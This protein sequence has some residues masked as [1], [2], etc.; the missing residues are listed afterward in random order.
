M[1]YDSKPLPDDELLT[2][3]SDE[4][5]ARTLFSIL[6]AAPPLGRVEPMDI[7][8]P[9]TASCVEYSNEDTAI[10]D[11]GD[12][13]ALSRDTEFDLISD[14][15]LAPGMDG[16]RSVAESNAKAIVFI[17]SGVTDIN[18]I[19]RAAS[20]DAEIVLLDAKSDG[21]EQIA[22]H[23][24][25]RTGV[26]KMH[27]VSY[28]APGELQLGNAT[29]SLSSITGAHR[30]GLAIVGTALAHDACILVCGSE[31]L[32]STKGEAFIQ[33]LAN[34]TGANVYG[35]DDPAWASVPGGDRDLAISQRAIGTFINVVP[36][37]R[38]GPVF[39]H[40]RSL[41]TTVC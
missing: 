31:D 10:S 8:I 24:Q 19:V 29:L 20:M 21:I 9:L 13:R 16:A 26:E 7:C 3:P 15:E 18:T 38:T 2:Q 40:R 12:A 34:V 25:G 1:T 33:A 22:S 37:Y 35:S 5:I 14:V 11:T 17:D 6:T 39:W 23:F 28:G 32:A 41:E 4:E 27:I 36:E 30:D